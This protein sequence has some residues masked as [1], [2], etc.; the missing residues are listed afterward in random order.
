MIIN[1]IEHLKDKEV[2]VVLKN[3]FKYQ[4]KCTDMEGESTNAVIIKDYKVGS[5]T[6]D[7][8]SISAI[9]EL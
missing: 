9:S 4:G 7:I 8:S 5:T 3:G 6:I 1:N 2:M